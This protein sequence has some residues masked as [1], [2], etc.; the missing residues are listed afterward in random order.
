[1]AE[2][3]ETPGVILEKRAATFLD[4][5]EM[6][7]EEYPGKDGTKMKVLARFPNGEPSVFLVWTPPGLDD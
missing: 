5:R 4:T 7:W 1:M 3:A 6:E 2:K